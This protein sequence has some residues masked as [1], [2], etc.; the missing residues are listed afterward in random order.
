MVMFS[1]S[2]MD[3]MDLIHSGRPSP[4]S[5]RMRVGPVP[6]MYVFVPSPF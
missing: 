6:M 1:L 3:L 4:E 2:I 5:M